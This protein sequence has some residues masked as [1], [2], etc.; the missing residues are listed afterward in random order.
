M[1]VFA[2]TIIFQSEQHVCIQQ[3]KK[4]VFFFLFPPP[5]TSHIERKNQSLG[6]KHHQSPGRHWQKET[7]IS[8]YVKLTGLDFS[9]DRSEMSTRDINCRMMRMNQCRWDLSSLMRKLSI[10]YSK[11]R[12]FAFFI[13]KFYI[14]LHSI[15]YTTRKT[16]ECVRIGITDR[17]W[18][19]F[20]Y[21][22]CDSS[23]LFDI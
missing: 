22:D 18:L 5:L 16:I 21:Y 9:F 11:K 12:L 14:I 17:L 23:K 3:R 8:R 10:I 2:T 4:N 7:S 13:C 1:C 6:F 19:L 15:T 20:H